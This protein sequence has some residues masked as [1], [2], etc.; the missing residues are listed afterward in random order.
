LAAIL[1]IPA[2]KDVN[3]KTACDWICYA[4]QFIHV[5]HYGNVSD[6]AQLK[7]DKRIHAMKALSNLAK[8]TGNYDFWLQIRQRYNLNWSTGTQKLNAF[9]RF[10][11]DNNALDAMIQWLRQ[12]IQVLPKSYSNFFVFS[13]LTGLRASEA[14]DSVRL[15]NA[16]ISGDIVNHDSG[17][18]NHNSEVQAQYY[19]PER[20]CL[21]HFRYPQIFLRRTKSAYISI[22]DQ[23]I[24]GIAKSVDKTPPPITA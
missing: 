2:A 3:Q 20:Q 4:K 24:L 10:F 16:D 1:T 19:N 21:E 7:P 6:L 9:T 22:V 11:D 13:T 18:R 8:F 12:A 17:M 15:I 14:I 5:L 23:E